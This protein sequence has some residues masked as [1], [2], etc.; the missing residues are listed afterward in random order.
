MKN[1]PGSDGQLMLAFGTF[2]DPTFA[3]IIRFLRVKFFRQTQPLD[4]RI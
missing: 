4:Q 1:G 3:D 2:I